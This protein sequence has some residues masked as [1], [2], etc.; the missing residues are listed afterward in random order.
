MFQPAALGLLCETQNESY[1]QSLHTPFLSL[2]SLSLSLSLFISLFLSPSLFHGLSLL[3]FLLLSTLSFFFSHSFLH[4]LYLYEM[5]QTSHRIFPAFH[6]LHYS[7]GTNRFVQRSF[8]PSYIYIYIYRCMCVCVCV[9]VCVCNLTTH[10][11]I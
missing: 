4:T 8:S 6:L 11:C 5:S 7:S 10:V 3:A 2:L 1:F 9:C